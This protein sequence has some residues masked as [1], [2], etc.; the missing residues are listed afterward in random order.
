[1]VALAILIV[2]VAATLSTL[3]DAMHASEAV[4]KMADIQDN[5][6]SGMNLMTRDLVQAGS[7]IP[8][9]GILIPYTNPASNPT[10]APIPLPVLRPSPPGD[11]YNFAGQ[12]AL[13]AIEPGPALGPVSV[14]HATDM[15][16]MIYADNKLDWTAM[17]P[18][19]NAASPK[20]NGVIALTG[21]TI[22]FDT[23]TSGCASLGSGNT[24]VVPGDLIMLT[25]SQGG[26]ILQVVTSVSGN[27]L[28][29]APGDAFNLNG[30]NAA[31]GTIN[32]FVVGGAFPPISAERVYMVTYYVSMTNPLIPKLIRQVNF[33]APSEVG[34]VIE[35]MQVT[36]DLNAP[37]NLPGINEAAINPPDSPNQIRDIN[38]L[39]AA[40]SEYPYSVTQK[41]FRAN[42]ITQVSMRSLTF[43]NRYN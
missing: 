38:L 16:T 7:G 35:D 15:I 12:S 30:V 31:S 13:T 3:R 32:S 36:Y 33:N 34:Q 24:A 14:G 20:C 17:A 27:K 37:T 41:Y 40:R 18:I 11:V 22:T 39:L 5:L 29:F 23:T 21:V 42:L 9:G 28:T 4:S 1:M 6:R 2:V 26:N 8:I 10:H 19:N 25:S 43:Q